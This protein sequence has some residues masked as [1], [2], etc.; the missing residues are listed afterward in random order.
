MYN[1]IGL[2][3]ELWNSGKWNSVQWNE[4]R[5][6]GAIFACFYVARVW[7]RQLGLLVTQ[8]VD[9]Y[10]IRPKR[11]PILLPC[12]PVSTGWTLHDCVYTLRSK[13]CDCRITCV[14]DASGITCWFDYLFGIFYRAMYFSKARYCDRM[15]SVC[16]SVS[17]SVT[18][19][20]CDHIGWNSSEIISPSVRLGCLLF[21][22]Q[23]SGVYSKGN[24]RKFLPKVTHPSVD[25]SVGDIRSQ[26]AAEWLQI[27]QRS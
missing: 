16:L 27:A 5:R 9:V 19:V 23:T 13:R 4:T 10:M 26:I 2:G 20:N 21:A 17:L 22:T 7:Q 18:L 15:S 25:L 24:T 14:R 12:K 8:R 6:I 11:P 3:L 1:Y